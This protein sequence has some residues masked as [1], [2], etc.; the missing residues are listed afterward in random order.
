MSGGSD[1]STF[2][3]S[4]TAVASHYDELMASVPYRMWVDYIHDI[5]REFGFDFATVLDVACGTGSVA[6]EFA[7]RGCTAVGVDKSAEMI[8]EA[9][10]KARQSGVKNVEFLCHDACTMQLNQLS[11]LAVSLFDSF[12]YIL[13]P[14]ELERAFACVQA[15]L[16]EGGYFVFDMNSEYALRENLF[17]QNNLYSR[18]PLRYNWVSSYDKVTRRCRVEMNFE[19]W[20]EDRV[21]KFSEVHHQ[22]AY[23]MDEVNEL[24]KAAG[25]EP[26]AV[27]DAYTFRSPRRATERIYFVAQRP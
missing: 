13:Q 11:D 19:R 4:F 26:V 9:C 18:G 10:E 2:A 12:N 25:F 7:R 17:T 15:A 20:D 21:E 24:L 1:D 23:D 3:D 22:R 8:E 14:D 16:V 27:Y 6:L 5:A